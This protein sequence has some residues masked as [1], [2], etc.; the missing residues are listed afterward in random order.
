MG[1]PVCGS[2]VEDCGEK[3]MMSFDEKYYTVR[4]FYCRNCNANIEWTELLND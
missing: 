3:R 2:H 1:C 4:L